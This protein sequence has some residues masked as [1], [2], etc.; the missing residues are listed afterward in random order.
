MLT[1]LL[2]KKAGSGE[3]VLLSEK[4]TIKLYGVSRSFLWTLREKNGLEV[5]HVRDRIFYDS[6]VLKKFFNNYKSNKN[7]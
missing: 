1:D 5:V 4:Q 6:E 3:P 7:K 2:E